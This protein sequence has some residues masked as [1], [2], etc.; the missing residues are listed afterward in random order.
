MESLFESHSYVVQRENN[1]G[2]LSSCNCV[3]MFLVPLG[4]LFSEGH[5][6]RSSQSSLRNGRSRVWLLKLIQSRTVKAEI[7]RSWSWQ[8]NTVWKLF[9]RYPTP[10][11]T[12]TGSV[13]L[14]YSHIEL[15]GKHSSAFPNRIIDENN[16]K[17][18]MTYVRFQTVLRNLGP[19]KKPVPAP[20]EEDMKGMFQTSLK[21][22]WHKNVAC[23][24]FIS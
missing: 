21:T 23:S 9:Q 13:I 8:R 5:P 7:K 16:G 22:P 14:Y 17:P 12:S 4:S 11:T 20:T 10:S 19:P 1:T 6:Q 15:D 3:S 2:C 24:L 18:P